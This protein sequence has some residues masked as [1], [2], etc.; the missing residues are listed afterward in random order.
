MAK[1][2][3]TIVLLVF[4]GA[5][6]LTLVLRGGAGAPAAP[7]PVR[8]VAPETGPTAAPA[9]SGSRLVAFYFH[10]AKRC[11]SCNT[12]E[13]LTRDALQ[14]EVQAGAVEIRPVDIDEPANAHFV[15][16]FQ[17]TMRTVVLAE[18]ADGRI[19]RWERLDECWQRFGDAPDF[20]DYVRTH[21]ARF[22]G[23]PATP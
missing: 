12:I 4:V 7:P 2:I 10:G 13:R 18:E 8:A 15:Q 5:A 17:L 19:T 14:P 3:T 9:P 1:T 20:T 6:L 22:R 16:D 23:S 21:L 11:A